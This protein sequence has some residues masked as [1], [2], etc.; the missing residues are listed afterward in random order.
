MFSRKPRVPGVVGPE[1]QQDR[2]ILYLYLF[3]Y[4]IKG[5]VYRVFKKAS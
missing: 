1:L 4:T 2:E 5:P 3:N